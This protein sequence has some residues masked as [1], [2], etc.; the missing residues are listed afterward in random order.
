MVARIHHGNLRLVIRGYANKARPNARKE[1]KPER[2]REIAGRDD[3]VKLRARK[4]VARSR[5]DTRT[6]AINSSGYGVPRLFYLPRR[7]PEI[8]ECSR[9][10]DITINDT[11][12]IPKLASRHDRARGTRETLWAREFCE[13]EIR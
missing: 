9:C 1:R 11:P 4:V 8:R 2:L 13:K 5:Q 3:S 7:Q 10:D 6:T 12:R